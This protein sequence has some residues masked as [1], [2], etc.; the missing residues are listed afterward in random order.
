MHFRTAREMWTPTEL[1]QPSETTRIP[2]SREQDYIR[3]K[4]REHEAEIARCAQQIHLLRMELDEART[5]EARV[6]T[7][8]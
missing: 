7:R 8:P 1:P 2:P 3:A 4:I 5:P 6:A